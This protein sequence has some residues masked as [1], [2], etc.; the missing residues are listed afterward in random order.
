VDLVN[1]DYGKKNK[2]PIEDVI[3]Y[4]ANKGGGGVRSVKISRKAQ[5]EM[6]VPQVFRQQ[7]IR[8]Y[9]KKPESRKVTAMVHAAFMFFLKQF[10]L[11]TGLMP[12]FW[13]SGSPKTGGPVLPP[14]PVQAAAGRGPGP[15]HLSTSVG[16]DTT[17]EMGQTA[18]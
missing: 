12:Y 8:I 10:S 11:E 13:P 14:A 9:S 16:S 17:V 15:H 1:I 18:R 2:D 4:S 5:G 3:A 6:V 7:F